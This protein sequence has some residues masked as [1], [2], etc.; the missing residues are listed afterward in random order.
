MRGWCRIIISAVDSG[1]PSIVLVWV[2]V[3]VMAVDRMLM[4][5]LM[6]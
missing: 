2:L 6:S 3:W 5:V 1:N 4:L